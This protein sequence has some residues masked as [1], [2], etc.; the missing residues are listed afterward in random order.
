MNF[1]YI[2]RDLYYRIFRYLG[3]YLNDNILRIVCK[4]CGKKQG[5][6]KQ[7]VLYTSIFLSIHGGFQTF[8]HVE[9]LNKIQTLNLLIYR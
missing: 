6:I 1:W 3:N 7:M 2:S 8:Y 9:I 4:V 5:S